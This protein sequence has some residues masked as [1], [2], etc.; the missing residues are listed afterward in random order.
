MNY[1][2]QVL[3]NI[4]VGMVNIKANWEPFGNNWRTLKVGD[5]VIT[6]NMALAGVNFSSIVDPGE[7]RKWRVIEL[8]PTFI[9]AICNGQRMVF[10]DYFVDEHDIRRINR[11]GIGKMTLKHYVYRRT[12]KSIFNVPKTIKP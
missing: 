7:F 12:G 10:S 6:E 2:L 3:R 8:C 9:V 4:F 5:Y 1:L 11:L